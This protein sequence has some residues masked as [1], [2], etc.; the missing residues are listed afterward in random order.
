MRTLVNVA[1]SVSAASAV[2]AACG[3]SQPPIGAPGA[4]PQVSALAARASSTNY[5]VVYSFGGSD[6]AYPYAGLIEL[7]G[8]LYGTTAYGGAY[9]C[10]SNSGCGTVFRV[11]LGGTETVLHNFGAGSDGRN[12][13]AGLVDVGGT[14]YG[15]TE[16]GGSYACYSYSGGNC[17]TVFS[18]TPSGTENVLHSFKG[19]RE[20]GADPFAP[21]INVKGTLYGTTSGG[22]CDC[23]CYYD[24]YVN[25]G[26]VF[27]ITAAGKESV[28]HNFS[29]YPNDGALPYAG[30]FDV[31][32]TLYGTTLSGGKHGAGGTVFSITTGG[33]ET[34]LHSFGGGHDG[35]SP[36]AALIKLKRKLYGTTDGGG[37]HGDGA[38]FSITPSGTEKILHSFAGGSSDGAY[39]G[40]S[41]IEVKGMLYGTTAGGG[42][43]ARTSRGGGT[44][45]SITPDGTEKVLHSFGNG[46]D[47]RNPAANLIDVNGTLYGTTEAGGTHDYGTVFSLTP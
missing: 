4:M 23:V 22:G 36:H 21:L 37:A 24:S 25:C 10:G 33:T 6:G 8:K 47:G 40:G 18:I 45:F 30:L 26:T 43:Y 27:S 38:V 16:N 14:L 41:L 44:V 31:K 42:P 46:S 39:P 1:F 2:L 13:Y 28:L 15:T 5:K 34:V 32:S 3:A 11:T 35:A 12:P 9:S 19:A 17:G 7:K 20:D 29:G